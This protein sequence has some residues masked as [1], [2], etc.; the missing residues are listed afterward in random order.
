MSTFDTDAL[1][2]PG[3]RIPTRPGVTLI[4]APPS[5]PPPATVAQPAAAPPPPPQPSAAPAP[6]PSPPAALNPQQPQSVPTQT[7]GASLDTDALVVPGGRIPSRPGITL[8]TAPNVA[9]PISSTPAA[10]ASRD[11]ITTGASQ[12]AGAGSTAVPTPITASSLDTDALVIPGAR[13][14]ARPGITLITAPNVVQPLPS[15]PT[16]A[17][18][19]SDVTMSSTQPEGLGETDAFIPPGVRMLTRPGIVLLPAP[20][21]GTPDRDLSSVRANQSETNSTSGGKPPVSVTITGHAPPIILVAG[22]LTIKI[23]T[24]ASLTGGEGSL[25]VALTPRGLAVSGKGTGGA[26]TYTDPRLLGDASK[27]LAGDWGRRAGTK[28]SKR[29][30]DPHQASWEV[31]GSAKASIKVGEISFNYETSVSISHDPF[32]P[33]SKVDAVTATVLLPGHAGTLTYGVTITTTPV[34]RPNPGDRQVSAKELNRAI[35]V[36]AAAIGGTLFARQVARL[37]AS[38]LAGSGYAISLG[39]AV[40]E[41]YGRR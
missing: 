22:A 37:I 15:T 29:F 27:F 32:A 4:P 24:S 26:F 17:S 33:I 2:V 20:A 14:A 39:R 25:D 19:A 7:Q 28:F 6:T 31:A 18:S 16:P 8:I 13:V 35:E 40:V 38:D 11:Q 23:E 41:P 36:A 9:Q 5:S 12:S 1:I 30:P 21:I 34:V 10:A 3:A